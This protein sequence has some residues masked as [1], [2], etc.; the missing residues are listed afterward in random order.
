M[1]LS[2]RLRVPF[3]NAGGNQWG[4]GPIEEVYSVDNIVFI[5]CTETAKIPFYANT[6]IS[7]LTTV[8][9]AA[10]GTLLQIE[11]GEFLGWEQQEKNSIHLVKKV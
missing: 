10:V 1:S 8:G 5:R 6:Y 9:A 4:W 2:D 3:Q 11:F 7:G